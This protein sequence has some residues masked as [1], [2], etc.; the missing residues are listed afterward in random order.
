MR[1]CEVRYIVEPLRKLR[2]PREGELTV[3]RLGFGVTLELLRTGGGGFTVLMDAR[4]V[5]RVAPGRIYGEWKEF[6]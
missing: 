3:P 2:D 4:R 1:R 6:S 5:T